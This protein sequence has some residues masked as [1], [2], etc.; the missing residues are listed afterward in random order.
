MPESGRRANRG[1]REARGELIALLDA[2]VV[3]ERDT[4]ARQVQLLERDPSVDLIVG[5]VEQFVSPELDP[6]DVP[7]PGPPSSTSRH[8]ERAAHALGGGAARQP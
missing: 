5:V 6:G 4:L 7:S 1:I 2:D 8:S 3:W